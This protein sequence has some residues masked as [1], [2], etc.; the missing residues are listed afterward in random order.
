VQLDLIVVE[1]EELREFALL[2]GSNRREDDLG[3]AHLATGRHRGLK[4]S[5]IES[6]L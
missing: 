2:D 5:L 1:V 3:V 6:P 4:R